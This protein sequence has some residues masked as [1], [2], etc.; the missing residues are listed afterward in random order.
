MTWIDPKKEL[1]DYHCKIK[2][3]RKNGNI[4][5]GYFWLDKSVWLNFFGVKTSHFQDEQGKF[6]F[7]VIGWEKKDEEKGC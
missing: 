4:I 7:D 3:K 5:N 6:L 2:I 1:P